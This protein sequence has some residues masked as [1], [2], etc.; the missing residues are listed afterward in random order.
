MSL[1]IAVCPPFATWRGY[2]VDSNARMEGDVV[3]YQCYGVFPSWEVNGDWVGKRRYKF[4]DGTPDPDVDKQATCLGNST[5]H[6]PIPECIG[7]GPN[8]V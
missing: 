3:T 6:P 5:W 8:H 7:T 1:L 4:E 2:L